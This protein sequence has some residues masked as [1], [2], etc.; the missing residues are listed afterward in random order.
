MRLFSGGA[1]RLGDDLTPLVTRVQVIGRTLVVPFLGAHRTHNRRMLGA[2]GQFR[3]VLADANPRHRGL[4]F[5][6]GPAVGMAR[7]EIER[8]DL[9]GAA[10]H[11]QDDA[12]P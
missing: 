1:L 10:R 8:V 7:L 9:T 5:P 2:L 6:K 12:R 3:Q 4:N 11:P